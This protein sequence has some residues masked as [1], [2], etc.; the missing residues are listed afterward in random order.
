MKIFLIGFMGSGKT[1]WGRELSKKLGIPFFDL[2]EM[3]VAAKGKSIN[4]IFAEEGEEQFRLVEMETLHL[5][6]ESHESFVMATGGGAPCYYN[7]IEYMTRSGMAV[8]INCS[9]ETLFRRL[10]QEKERRPL[11]RDLGDDQL[12]SYILKKYADRRIYYEQATV[13]VDEENM[14]AEFLIQ[15]LFHA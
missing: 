6:S 7:N 12:K 1:Y 2:D 15:K 4:A 9:I 14:S 8:W 3:I 13:I 11:I 10:S 5:I